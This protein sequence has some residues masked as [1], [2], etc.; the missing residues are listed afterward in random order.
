MYVE[1]TQIQGGSWREKKVEFFR[2]LKRQLIYEKTAYES[3]WFRISSFLLGQQYLKTDPFTSK[4]FADYKVP[5]WKM[6]VTA[7]RMLSVFRREFARLNAGAPFFEVLP[8]SDEPEDQK[9]SKIFNLLLDYLWQDGVLSMQRKR[10]Q[11]VQWALRT[12]TGVW[13][14]EFDPGA[15]SFIPEY[16]KSMR[17]ADDYE[18]DQLGEMMFSRDGEPLAKQVPIGEEYDKD[19]HGNYIEVGGVSLGEIRVNTVSPFDFWCPDR[20]T[21]VQEAPHVIQYYM[22]RIETLRD[23]YPEAKD[24]SPKKLMPEEKLFSERLRN[25]VSGLSSRGEGID[26]DDV[27]ENKNDEGLVMVSEVWRRPTKSMPEGEV[28]VF[29]D[30]FLLYEGKN[31]YSHKHYPFIVFREIPFEGRFW[32]MSTQEHIM[33]LQEEYNR[34]CSKEVAAAEYTAD[35]IMIT[36]TGSK[37]NEGDLLAKPGV[38]VKC[39]GK[40]HEPQFLERGRTEISAFKNIQMRILDDMQEI[41]HQHEVSRGQVPRNVESGLALSWLSQ[42]DE[43]AAS[44]VL[45][46]LQECMEQAARM[47]GSL[48]VQFYD[49]PR[50]IKIVGV[51]N[52]V[53]AREFLGQDLVGDDPRKNYFDVRIRPTSIAPINP[54]AKK[55][56]LL[57]LVQSGFLNPQNPYDRRYFMKIWDSYSQL[58]DLHLE[59]RLDEARAKDVCEQLKK[60]NMVN[61]MPHEN[62]MIHMDVLV[63]Y[64]KTKEFYTLD[65]KIQQMFFQYMQIINQK[66][67]DSMATAVPGSGMMPPAGAGQNPQDVAASVMTDMGGPKRNQKVG[68]LEEMYGGIGYE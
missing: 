29:A 5:K 43:M 42:K 24:V 9:R 31:P 45:V 10:R 30:E 60:G 22:A 1:G 6:R 15:G 41:S 2:K 67:N 51:Q 44:P 7:N 36:Y 26:T 20:F 58:S 33:G 48:A 18:V 59:D 49:E 19:E 14:I 57:T 64:M 8:A 50:M 3:L 23:L 55:S 62:H 63:K 53:D 4:F 25:L 13:K 16:K 46:D 47:I 66:V 21:N 27:A 40:G 32:G 56:E 65:E 39:F 17:F 35:P 28:L 61:P 34:V 54:A 52:D 37:I 11:M 38:V 68:A 12:G